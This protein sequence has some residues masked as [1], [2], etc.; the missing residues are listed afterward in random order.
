[1]H[2]VGDALH[3][4]AESAGPGSARS[5]ISTPITGSPGQ[6]STRE[7]AKSAPCDAPGR[8]V[9][10][11]VERRSGQWVNQAS[12]GMDAAERRRRDLG[13]RI[14]IVVVLDKEVDLG[15]DR[16]SAFAM[17]RAGSPAL[18]K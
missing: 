11:S 7:L 5:P 17:A 15:S 4:I 18:S 6:V 1:M 10:G 8:P 14:G 12:P 16:R 3:A 13:I 2:A 9:I